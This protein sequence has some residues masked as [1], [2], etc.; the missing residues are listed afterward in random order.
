MLRAAEHNG[1]TVPLLDLTVL[2][3]MKVGVCMQGQRRLVC[4][5][6]HVSTRLLVYVCMCMFVCMC[7][8]SLQPHDICG[9]LLETPHVNAGGRKR[10]P[11]VAV[12]MHNVLPSVSEHA[13]AAPAPAPAPATPQASATA[14]AGASTTQCA[15]TCHWLLL[16]LM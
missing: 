13:T 2:H 14:T 5:T 11:S 3:D 10:N 8:I 16:L 9:G 4:S 15:W 6:A 7:G 1:E 12:G